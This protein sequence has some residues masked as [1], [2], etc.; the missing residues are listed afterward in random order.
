MHI[1][2]TNTPFVSIGRSLRALDAQRLDIATKTMA[3]L[4][5]LRS[6]GLEEIKVEEGRYMPRIYIRAS[7]A[8]LLLDGAVLAYEHIG[9]HERRYYYVIRDDC[10]IRWAAGEGGSNG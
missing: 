5:W 9:C 10:E 2:M 3:C 4:R 7:G 1:T 8:A 6:L